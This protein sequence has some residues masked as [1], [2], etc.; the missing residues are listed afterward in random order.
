VEM[1]STPLMSKLNNV[2]SRVDSYTSG[3]VDEALRMLGTSG[4]HAA[5]EFMQLVGVPRGVAWRVLCFP[6]HCRKQDRRKLPRQEA[7]NSQVAS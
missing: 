4:R 7:L 3:R 1:N 6:S 2:D 5:L